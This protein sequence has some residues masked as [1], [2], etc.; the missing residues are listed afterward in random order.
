ML[1][2]FSGNA[3]ITNLAANIAATATSFSVVD[4]TGWPT[5][6]NAPFVVTLS[7]GSINEEKVLCSGRS[8]NTVTVAAGGRGFDGTTAQAHTQAGVV[9]H[10][11][12]AATIRQAN[13]YVNALIHPDFLYGNTADR[14]APGSPGLRPNTFHWA[15]DD[16]VLTRFAG[17]VWRIVGAGDIL[18]ASTHI[19]GDPHNQYAKKSG[20][21]FTGPPQFAA[22]PLV[23]N[24]LARKRYVDQI[25]RDASI[26]AMDINGV[27]FSETDMDLTT[28]TKNLFDAVTVTK[29]AG[30]GTMRC[31]FFAHASFASRVNTYCRAYM[32]WF[33]DGASSDSYEVD[34]TPRTGT[35]GWHENISPILL[36]T[37]SANTNVRLRAWI[38]HGSSGDIFMEEYNVVVFKSRAS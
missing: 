31:L 12:D 4:S 8:G 3:V 33:I 19:A 13:E 2:E 6:T 10:T 17:G 36:V 27:A 18:R 1:K 35:A 9:A 23:D 32:E 25:A 29:P 38:S 11:I 22:D 5:G 37:K 20:D 26:G 14:P 7:R 30:W 21:L 34:F 24:T 15:E 16:Q 28:G